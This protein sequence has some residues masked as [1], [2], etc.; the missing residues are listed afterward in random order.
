MERKYPM[1]YRGIQ[2]SMLHDLQNYRGIQISILQ[3]LQIYICRK[4][5]SF[6]GTPAPAHG[7]STDK[8][9]PMAAQKK[10]VQQCK[11]IPANAK[12]R[13]VFVF[14]EFTAISAFTDATP[15]RCNGDAFRRACCMHLSEHVLC[16]RHPCLR[17][18]AFLPFTGDSA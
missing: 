17:P 4:P 8:Q 13:N 9:E 12:K 5:H 3:D 6:F 16:I 14:G 10:K 7:R 1:D 2:I 18:K 15:P 11:V